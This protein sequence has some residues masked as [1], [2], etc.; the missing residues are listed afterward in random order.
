MQKYEQIK[1]NKPHKTTQS[2]VQ[3]YKK[4]YLH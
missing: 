1:T 4:Q 3:Y 2:L